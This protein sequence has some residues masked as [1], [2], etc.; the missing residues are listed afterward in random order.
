MR[1]R[2]EATV[3]LSGMPSSSFVELAQ[4]NGQP[5]ILVGRTE[6][7]AD[8]VHANNKLAAETAVDVFAARGF[9][10]SA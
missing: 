4:R 1:Y 10:N 6:A 2:A 5:L 3:V 9:K 8:H 7:G